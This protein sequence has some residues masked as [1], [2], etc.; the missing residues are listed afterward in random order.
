MAITFKNQQVLKDITW[1]VKRGE[2]VGLVG[3]N[4]AG[5]TTQLQVGRDCRTGSRQCCGLKGG[6][7]HAGG[8]AVAGCGAEGLGADML[9]CWAAGKLGCS[10]PWQHLRISARIM[11]GSPSSLLLK[12]C[13]PCHR[14]VRS[15]ASF[16]QIIIGKLTPDSG[17]V[18]KAK[19]NMKIAYLTQ[20]GTGPGLCWGWARAQRGTAVL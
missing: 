11:T 5:K 8:S 18:I 19:E 12:A 17:E 4:G 3:I 7:T 14:D 10:R 1:D 2:R 9:A 6:R 13:Y 16:V 20:V 15:C